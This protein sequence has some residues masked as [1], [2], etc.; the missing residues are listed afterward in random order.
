M[1]TYSH[2]FVGGAMQKWLPTFLR[3]A[4]MGSWEENLNLRIV[5]SCA[6]VR[7]STA[8]RA[9][10]LQTGLSTRWNIMLKNKYFYNMFFFSPLKV[11]LDSSG[12]QMDFL[13]SIY[14]NYFT[15][16][17]LRNAVVCF[18]KKGKFGLMA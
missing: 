7:I 16:V 1:V 18:F 6:S 11:F 15:A 17:S 2:F 9:F 3:M 5:N 4:F 10:S 14:W 12:G 8:E 13:G